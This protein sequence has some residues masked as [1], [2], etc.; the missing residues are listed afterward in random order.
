MGLGLEVGTLTFTLLTPSTAAAVAE[1]RVLICRRE[2]GRGPWVLVGVALT[3]RPGGSRVGQWGQRVLIRSP[4]RATVEV[5]GG[6]I[7]ERGGQRE[8]G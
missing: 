8:C 7:C 6:K 2:A 1:A 5:Q 4:T 3:Q